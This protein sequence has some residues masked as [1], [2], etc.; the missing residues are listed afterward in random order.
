MQRR[1]LHPD[2]EQ[3][4]AIREFAR[5]WADLEQGNRGFWWPWQQTVSRQGI[6][7]CGEPER[8]KTWMMDFFYDAVPRRK[9]RRLHFDYFMDDVHRRLYGVKRSSNPMQQ[10]VKD[11]AYEAPLL[12]I[13]DLDVSDVDDA[14][15][16]AE[17]LDGLFK[18]GVT[19]VTT[20]SRHPEEL[21]RHGLLRPNFLPAI[22]LLKEHTRIVD[23]RGE[24]IHRQEP[25]EV[26]RV[27]FSPVD[28]LAELRMAEEFIR[29]ASGRTEADGLIRL[30]AQEILFCKRAEGLI[31][32]EF[33]AL[34]GPMRAQND[35]IDIA[36]QHHTL[37]ISNIPRM[38]GS[39]DER[40]R[41]FIFLIDTL[42]AHGVRLVAS[43]N[44]EPERLYCGERLAF[45]FKRT[46]RRLREM[47]TPAYL[48]SPHRGKGV[49]L[50]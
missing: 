7:L 37:F 6:Y 46:A 22:D 4:L 15:I 27:Y 17:L 9:K 16:L 5:L 41:R 24:P 21:Y 31:W 20:A 30:R 35:Y 8:G 1:G 23:L 34:C 26:A 33:E 28:E 11:L 50:G 40:A 48:S 36:R 43:S 10:V 3:M 29:L 38:D 45:E 42:Y 2:P 19:L 47:Q 18:E 32:F 49:I 12:C 39:R 44:F 25:Q 13:D 14:A